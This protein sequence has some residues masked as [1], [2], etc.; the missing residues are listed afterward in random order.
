M[1]LAERLSIS[2][3]TVMAHLDRRHVQRRNV[4]KQWDHDA[5]AA[6]A[7]AYASGAS[8]AAI[9]KTHDLDPQTVAN[10]LRHAGIKIRPRRGWK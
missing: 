5:L 8:L 1:Q 10:R 3:T 4:A 6:A 2:R 7:D 9:A